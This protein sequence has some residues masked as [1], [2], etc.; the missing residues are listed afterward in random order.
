MDD[1]ERLKLLHGPYTP[2]KARRGDTL[3]CEYRGC[4]VRVGGMSSDVPIQWPTVFKTG[5]RSL[6]VCG[7]LVRAIRTESVI[8]IAHHWG[9]NVVTVWFW[10]KAL[11]VPRITEGTERLYEEYKPEKLPDDVTALGREHARE[12]EVLERM[13]ETKRGVPAHPNTVAALTEAAKQPKSEDWK[14]QARERMAGKRP[15]NSV[16]PDW[17]PEED[18]LL[19]TDFDREIASK[20]GRTIAGVRGR[21]KNLGIPA[22]RN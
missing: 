8:A 3:S 9:V 4:N 11:G 22:Y 7:E 21:R 10:R 20:T 13:A 6:I 19:G 15:L 12:P 17:K 16:R 2:P 14:R 1:G 18:A 5:R